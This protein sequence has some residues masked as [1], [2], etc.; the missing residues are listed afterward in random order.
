MRLEELDVRAK[1]ACFGAVLVCVF[2]FT[3]P[4]ANAVVLVLLLLALLATRTPL[5]GLGAMLAGLFPIL[6][7]IVIFTALFT[8]G[9][10]AG[11]A[12]IS[13]AG[14]HATLPGLLVG[15][16]FAARIVILVLASFAF[17][18]T[19]SVEDVLEA[20]SRAHAP[21]W[22]SIMIATAI[23]F[24]PT[25]GRKLEQIQ[26]AQRARGA[27]VKSRGPKAIL[28][29]VP[30]M[31]PLL[32]NSILLAEELAVALTSRG[33]GATGSMTSMRDLRFQRAD[34]VLFAA[35]TLLTAA[36]LSLRFGYQVGAL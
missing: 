15:V 9:A 10:S 11:P 6:L 8:P 34:L 30:I 4:R 2:A 16:N 12:L 19:S 23:A 32:T 21:Y 3:D 7:F 18:T 13:L 22:F 31:V 5:A 36:A 33:Y 35:S 20:L 26:Q 27:R 14:L 29:L 17:T 25:M 28:S 24:V 1:A